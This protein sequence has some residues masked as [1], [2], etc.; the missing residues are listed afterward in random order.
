[1]DLRNPKTQKALLGGLLVFLVLYFWYARIYSK[2]NELM[3]QKQIQYEYLLTDLKSVEMKA[4][5]FETLKE[6]YQ[7]LLER[8]QKVERLLPEEEQIPEFL[9]QMHSA[10]RAN[11]TGVM[12]IVPQHPLPESFYNVKSFDMQISGSYHDLG[13]FFSRVANFP[14]LANV[15][16]VTI[17]ALPQEEPAPDQKGKSITASLKLTTYYVKEEERLKRIEF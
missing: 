13:G 15:S 9:M 5:S 2:T 11:Q 16:D 4:R 14:F 8:Y 10:A 7:R 3:K 12:E 17:A 6:E 1:M